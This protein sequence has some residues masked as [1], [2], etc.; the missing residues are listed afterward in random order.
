MNVLAT[1]QSFLRKLKG[2]NSEYH[3][4]GGDIN[5]YGIESV[6]RCRSTM[7]EKPGTSTCG[8]LLRKV[9]NNN[10]QVAAECMDHLVAGVDTTGDAMCVLMWKMSTPE[11]AGVQD[12]LFQELSTVSHSF[13]PHTQTASIVDLDSLP[14]LEAV[15]K[16]GLRWRP[17]VPMTLFRSVP[18]GEAKEISGWSIPP[19]TVVG[20]Q[21]YSLHRNPEVF[22]NPDSF[23]P[24]RW[25]TEDEEKLRAM[26]LHFWP[27]SSGARHC[28]GHKYVSSSPNCKKNPCSLLI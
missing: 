2:K 14:Y 12:K 18:P 28:L 4:R 6:L 21:A 13:D 16:E 23:D 20:C 8:K 7:T 24:D 3:V 17:P 27:F 9:P 25:L 15:I 11:C 26:K 1:A 19:G 10:N 5:T 22:D